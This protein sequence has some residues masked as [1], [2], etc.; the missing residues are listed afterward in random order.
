MTGR[1]AGPPW[2][3]L[4]HVSPPAVYL[5]GSPYSWTVRSKTSQDTSPESQPLQYP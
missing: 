3:V 2:Q 5:A 4:I 1:L